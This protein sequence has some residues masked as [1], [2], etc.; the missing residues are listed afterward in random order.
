MRKGHSDIKNE[1]ATYRSV[2]LGGHPP[3]HSKTTILRDYVSWFLW[4]NMGNMEI[5]KQKSNK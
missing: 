3:W 5:K 4:Y 1:E 2:W